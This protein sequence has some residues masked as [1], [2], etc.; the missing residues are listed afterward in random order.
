MNGGDFGG[1]ELQE[2]S[3]GIRGGVWREGSGGLK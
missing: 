2:G 3:A 1:E